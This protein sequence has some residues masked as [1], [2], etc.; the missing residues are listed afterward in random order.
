MLMSTLLQIGKKVVL[1]KRITNPMNYEVFFKC[2]DLI[3]SFLFYS[4]SKDH[5]EFGFIKPLTRIPETTLS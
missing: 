1:L 5:R 4:F 3:Q 2:N